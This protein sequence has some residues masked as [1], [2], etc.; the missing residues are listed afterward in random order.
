[1]T[2]SVAAS[3]LTLEEKKL[4]GTLHADVAALYAAL[5]VL[6]PKLDADVGVTDTNY[7]ALCTPAAQTTSA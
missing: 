4:L 7:T 3:L 2:Q 6:L 5:A 1:M